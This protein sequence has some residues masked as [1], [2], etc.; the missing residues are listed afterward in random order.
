LQTISKLTQTNTIL[1]LLLYDYNPPKRI[2]NFKNIFLSGIKPN[3]LQA[4]YL[5]VPMLEIGEDL[6]QPEP[7]QQPLDPPLTSQHQYHQLH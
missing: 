7:P 5:N 6:V 3:T 4:G 1:L 2:A